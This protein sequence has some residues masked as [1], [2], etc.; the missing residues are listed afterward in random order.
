MKKIIYL[1]IF[2]LSNS[3]FADEAINWE[4]P[5]LGVTAGY[6]HGSADAQSSTYRVPGGF[7]QTSTVNVINGTGTGTLDSNNALFGLKAGYSWRS[8]SLVYGV[9]SSISSI[10]LKKSVS[11][12][13]TITNTYN[14]VREVDSNNLLTLEGKLGYLWNEQSLFYITAGIASTDLKLKRSFNDY[15][16]GSP[17]DTMSS[18]NSINSIKFG[19]TIGLG[20]ES[21]LSNNWFLSA[22]YKFTKFSN[23]S[24]STNG[25]IYA[26]DGV[27]YH[28]ETVFNDKTDL[29]IN[30]ITLG[31]SK[32]F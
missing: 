5:Y 26:G 6:A 29:D 24:G 25:L 11:N 16:A 1:S 15:T 30:L 18:S 27:S 3:V 13:A 2:I 14:I 10:N 20:L 21:P 32:H 4:G 31:I 8:D 23:I 7:Y 28:S 22:E 19:P 9:T 12:S 17:N